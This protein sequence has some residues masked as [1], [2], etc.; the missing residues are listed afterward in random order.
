MSQSFSANFPQASKN[1]F[2]PDSGE[3][4]RLPGSLDEEISTPTLS[5]MVKTKKTELLFTARI[6][7]C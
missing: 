6:L 2:Q 4:R 3:P 5:A 7:K 1:A